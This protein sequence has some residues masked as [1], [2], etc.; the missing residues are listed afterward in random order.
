MSTCT[1]PVDN[2]QTLQ[3]AAS[4]VRLADGRE[5]ALD[6]LSV[7]ELQ[8]LQWEQEQQF[9]Q[10]MMALPRGSSARGRAIAQAYDT[11]CS[12]LAAQE[13]DRGRPLV[14]G[15]DPRYVALVLGLLKQQET[16]GIGRP[17]L[18]EVGY[19]SGALLAEVGSRGYAA[20]GIEV[21]AMMRDQAAS[22]L[23]ERYADGLLLGDLRC[24]DER[25]LGGRPTLVFWNDVLEHVPPDE[26][27][28]YLD[29]IYRL[30]TPGGALVTITPNWLLR[31]SDVTGD[32]CPLRTTARGL[33][34]KEYRLAEVVALLRASG[35]HRVATPLFAT[36]GRMVRCGRG[37]VRVKQWVEP[38][39]DLLPVRAA[40]L[41]CRGLAM[42]TTIA[43]KP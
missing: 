2:Q 21:S 37:G 1:L 39:L 36:H 9:A 20:G 15:F 35:F 17:R 6:G 19:G 30:L 16:L 18:F 43:W 41:L 14:M 7:R 28:E 25:E 26:I 27:G 34:L 33:H 23:G 10:V 12:I 32:F 29:A 4:R 24:V 42:S 38:W 5:L 13:G 22:H 8:S 31:P 11:I 40:H 3:D